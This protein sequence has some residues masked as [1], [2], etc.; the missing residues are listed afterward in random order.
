MVDCRQSSGL[1]YVLI[2]AN[3]TSYKQESKRVQHRPE[4]AEC[5]WGKLT[6]EPELFRN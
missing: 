6:I 3:L 5:W 1:V 2:M 4:S